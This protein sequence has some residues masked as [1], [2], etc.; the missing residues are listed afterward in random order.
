MRTSTRAEIELSE[1]LQQVEMVY[2]I[3]GW[4]RLAFRLEHFR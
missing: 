1:Q 3:E 4:I 2:D